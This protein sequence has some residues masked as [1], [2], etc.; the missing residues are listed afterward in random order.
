[1]KLWLLKIK[2]KD[3]HDG[4][5]GMVVR[6]KSAMQARGLAAENAKVEGP[7]CWTYETRSTCIE[8][9]AEGLPEII[10]EDVL[11]S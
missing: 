6:A 11:W 5:S 9:V 4:C 10:L 3:Q 8:L 7:Y 1:M 2:G